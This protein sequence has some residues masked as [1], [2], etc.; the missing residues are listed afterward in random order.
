M[1]K[2]LQPGK[3][4]QKHVPAIRFYHKGF[5]IALIKMMRWIVKLPPIPENELDRTHL[6]GSRTNFA[7][8]AEY[9]AGASQI[10]KMGE[11]GYLRM[12]CNI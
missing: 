6:H 10:L 3:R 12:P 2:S 9:S 11:C 7:A 4:L 8:V 1:A 5:H